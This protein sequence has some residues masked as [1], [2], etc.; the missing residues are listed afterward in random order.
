MPLYRVSRLSVYD[1]PA[2]TPEQ[3]VE[4]IAVGII[5]TRTLRKELDHVEVF[6]AAVVELPK[7]VGAEVESLSPGLG[8]LEEGRARH[9]QTTRSKNFGGR[10]E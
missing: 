5:P 2:E 7:A 1:V 4:K 10:L 9:Q 8:D 6:D 3:A